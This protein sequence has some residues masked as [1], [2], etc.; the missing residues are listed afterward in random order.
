MP[1]NSLIKIAIDGPAGAGK[2]TVAQLV[3]QKLGYTYLDTGAMYRAITLLVLRSRTEVTDSDGITELIQTCKIDIIRNKGASNE[4]FLDGKNITTDIR[5]QDVSNSVSD[6]SN[7]LAVRKMLVEMQRQM[8]AIGGVVLDGRDIG[9]VVLPDAEL[10]IYLI[11]SLDVRAQR[12]HLELKDSK[13]CVSLSDL[14][15]AIDIRD[16]KDAKNAFGPM[17]A[18]SGA[19]IVNTDEMAINEV[20]KKIVDLAQEKIKLSTPNIL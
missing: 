2:S 15:K 17:R 16:Q 7:I 5:A 11:A 1:E 19:V 4:I 18:A 10:K 14:T 8:S 3:A 6:V 20:V 9:T 12:R 13:D